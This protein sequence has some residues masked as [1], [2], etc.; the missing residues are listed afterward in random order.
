MLVQL[1]LHALEPVLVGP[2]RHIH[3]SLQRIGRRTS[4]LPPFALYAA[5]P[6]AD[7][8]GGSVPCPRPCW[9]WQLARLRRPGARIRVPMF[10]GVTHGALGGRLHPWRRGRSPTRSR[11]ARTHTGY[12]QLVRVDQPGSGRMARCMRAARYF[13]LQ[14]L[15]A[16]TS[17][18]WSRAH[19]SSPWHLWSPATADV[20]TARLLQ[21]AVP[22]FGDV[23]GPLLDPDRARSG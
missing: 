2:R 10:V 6:R 13:S 3:G 21:V 12:T 5:F 4:L 7:Y 1:P 23:R 9:A 16:P 11:G 20:Q 22:T 14:R 17:I 19:T 8:Y 15:P 18:S